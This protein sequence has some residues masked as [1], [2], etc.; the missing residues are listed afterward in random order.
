VRG[1]I[2]AVLL[3][4]FSLVG[5]TPPGG[6]N[7][8][9]QPN[10]TNPSNAV[11]AQ[12]ESK[13]NEPAKP[14]LKRQYTDLSGFD[15]APKHD[16][17]TT[18]IGG[19]TRSFGGETTLYAPHRAK[20]FDLHPQLSWTHPT[21]VQRFIVT[22]M[23]SSGAT[24]Y[25]KEV[26]GRTFRYPDDAP[27]LHPGGT[28]VWTV[29]P[30]SS[31]MGP[32][33]EPAEILVV[34]DPERSELRDELSKCGQDEL[35]QAEVFVEHRIWYDA[36]GKLSHLIEERPSPDLYERRAEIYEE[37]SNTTSLAADDRSSASQIL[38]QH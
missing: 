31:L 11:S 2:G 37:V 32:R 7:G 30:G 35:S 21:K 14:K 34:A 12:T 29:Q 24:I 19:G 28:Y 10:Q 3:I 9:A 4:S 13:S 27:A 17:H 25:Q 5:Q 33:S 36:I 18:Q 38:S 20:S 15:L 22:V 8:T 23:D 16:T 6:S 1:H 26:I